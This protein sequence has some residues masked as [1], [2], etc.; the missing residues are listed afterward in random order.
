VSC[1]PPVHLQSE[2]HVDNAEDGRPCPHV[3]AQIARDGIPPAEHEVRGSDE[4]R[5]RE[6]SGRDVSRRG[7]QSGLGEAVLDRAR[8]RAGVTRL[9]PSATMSCL[10]ILAPAVTDRWELTCAV[11]RCWRLAA[12]VLYRRGRFRTMTHR[13]ALADR[14]GQRPTRHVRP[15]VRPRI[16]HREAHEEEKGPDARDR[17]RHMVAKKATPLVA[18]SRH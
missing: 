2:D 11:T 14:L 10:W 13:P 1:P 4:K 7:G 18:T 5:E 6:E 3:T 16:E 12:T 9:R 15:R 8:T 17:E